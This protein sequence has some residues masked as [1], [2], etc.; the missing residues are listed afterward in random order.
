MIQPA[1]IILIR[2]EFAQ[3]ELVETFLYEIFTENNLNEKNFNKVFLCISEAVVNAI[4]HGNHNDMNKMVF[5]GIDYSEKQ[6][7][8][9][10]KD[11]GKGFNIEKIQNPTSVENIKKESGRGI[12]IIKSLSD[13]VCFNKKGK[14]VQIKVKCE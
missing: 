5:I 13:G 11:Q 10:I 14:F 8:I 3:L 12:H 7:D 1:K 6:M 2:S 9:Y 4:E